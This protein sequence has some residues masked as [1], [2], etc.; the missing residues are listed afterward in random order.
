M[1]I[2]VKVKKNKFEK[3]IINI[4]Y[5]YL[6]FIYFNILVISLKKVY[7]YEYINITFKYL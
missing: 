3:R 5:N 6:Q 7:P 4:N 2:T 1:K